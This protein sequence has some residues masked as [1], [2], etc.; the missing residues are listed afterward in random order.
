LARFQALREAKPAAGEAVTRAAGDVSAV[1]LINRVEDIAA[2]SAQMVILSKS[3]LEDTDP[4]LREGMSGQLLSQAAAELTIAAELVQIA[5]EARTGRPAPPTRR[6]TR[7]LAL[8]DAID[9]L[10]RS[11]ANPVAQGLPLELRRTR[12][13]PPGGVAE[14]KQGLKGA[15]WTTTGS[16]YQQVIEVGGDLAF[17]L[18]FNTEWLTVIEGA[19]LVSSDIAKLL[20][21]IKEEISA[22]FKRLINAVTKTLTNIYDKIMALVGND[23]QDQGRQNIRE[24]LETIIKEGKIII[25]EQLVGKLYRLDQF[26]HELELWLPAIKTPVNKINHTTAAVVDLSGKFT[27]LVS[28]IKKVSDIAGLAML[29][30]VHP[31]DVILTGIQ[32]ALLASLVYAG[33]DYIGYEQVRFP[34]LTKGVAEVI[35]ENLLTV[36]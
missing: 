25:F 33:Y 29:V 13:I 24:W 12:A 16:I 14:A 31:L 5:E 27:I 20:E 6:A 8:R 21:N 2:V 4:K 36:A 7:G 35:Q 28:R 19:G 34:N 18:V 11:M 1:D 26:K 22:F 30:K 9:A 10:E 23:R 17:D 32:I 3:Y 15:A